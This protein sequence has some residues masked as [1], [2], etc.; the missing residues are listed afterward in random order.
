MPKPAREVLDAHVEEYLEC[1]AQENDW[2]DR[3]KEIGEKI[4][5]IMKQAKRK[6][7]RARNA[8]VTYSTSK[9][10]GYNGKV[11]DGLVE[12]DMIPEDIIAPARTT[13]TRENF[14][15]RRSK[16]RAK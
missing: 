7:F 11:I 10:K 6:S 16:R 5:G 2:K 8:T 14:S 12:A 13:G 3:K 4:K 9:T 1:A 15:V